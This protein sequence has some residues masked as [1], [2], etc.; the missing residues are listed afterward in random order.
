MRYVALFILDTVSYLCWIGFLCFQYILFVVH[1]KQRRP[2]RLFHCLTFKTILIK[3]VRASEGPSYPNSDQTPVELVALRSFLW[4][5]SAHFVSCNP[6]ER[7]P[8]R[9]FLS[10][11]PK[12]AL[13]LCGRAF[14]NGK[15]M[16][17]FRIFSSSHGCFQTL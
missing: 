15:P 3:K 11:P 12:V 9:R 2:T 1:K 17:S 16:R 14:G 8:E 6:T 10:I 5:F 7:K 4:G 13:N